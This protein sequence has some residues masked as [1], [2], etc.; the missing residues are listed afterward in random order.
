MKGLIAF[1]AYL[2]AIAIL[3]APAYIGLRLSGIELPFY[4]ILGI[5]ISHH[6][7]CTLIHAAVVTRKKNDINYIDPSSWISN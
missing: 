3:L 1:M 6:L 5:G 7:I 2:M 4:A